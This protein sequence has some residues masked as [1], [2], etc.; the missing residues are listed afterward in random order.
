MKTV[1]I[2]QVK[3][4]IKQPERQKRTLK[5]L[6]ISKLGRPVDI[7]ATPQVEGMI[8]AVSHLLKVEEI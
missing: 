6:G 4:G 7:E 3:S 5:A 8:K 2:T 1:R